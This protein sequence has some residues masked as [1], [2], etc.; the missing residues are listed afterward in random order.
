MNLNYINLELFL[1]EEEREV[2]MNIKFK[3]TG[4]IIQKRKPQSWF[5][6]R[7]FQ[8]ELKTWEK[9][10]D[11][12]ILNEIFFPIKYEYKGVN[13]ERSEKIKKF[14]NELDIKNEL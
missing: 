2:V 14:L 5:F 7:L 3:A 1:D 11:T 9:N 4:E 12:L 8:S 6:K 10:G 13:G